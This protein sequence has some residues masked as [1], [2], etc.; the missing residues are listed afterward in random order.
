VEK[1]FE[2]QKQPLK[3]KK[4]KQFSTQLPLAPQTTDGFASG[5]C[6]GTKRHTGNILLDGLMGKMTQ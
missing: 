6:F 1:I 3:S 4:S 5:C 2:V